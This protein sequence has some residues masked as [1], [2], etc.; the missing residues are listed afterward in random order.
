MMA[1]TGISLSN[2]FDFKR[3]VA[4][5]YVHTCNA[6]GCGEP[7][8]DGD[9]CILDERISGARFLYCCQRCSEK[10]IVDFPKEFL[11]TSDPERCGALRCSNVLTIGEEF[12]VVPGWSSL[13]CSEECATKQY[14]LVWGEESDWRQSKSDR[15]WADAQYREKSDRR[16]F[17]C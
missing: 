13:C 12:F 14:N 4:L 2:E 7:I 16:K 1:T 5:P 8:I 15:E 11:M 17:R 3:E 10:Q 6:K 9:T